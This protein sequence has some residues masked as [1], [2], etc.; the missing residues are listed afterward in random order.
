[1]S[2]STSTGRP[3]ARELADEE[4]HLVHRD[5]AEIGQPHARRHRRT[6]EIEARE[7]GRFRLQGRHP[8]MGTGQLQDTALRQQCAEAL[9]G[10]NRRLVVG[11]EIG[12]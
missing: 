3:A 9:P 7:P 4:A 2:P 12:H 11:D 6:R 5:D 1:V 8:V 10:R